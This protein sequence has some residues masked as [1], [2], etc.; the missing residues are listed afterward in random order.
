MLTGCIDNQI[1]DK[2][3]GQKY[4]I[5]FESLRLLRELFVRNLV[6]L[7]DACDAPKMDVEKTKCHRKLQVSCTS[8]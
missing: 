5:L 4:Q 2:Q 6:N 7:Y 3:L 1:F 8:V